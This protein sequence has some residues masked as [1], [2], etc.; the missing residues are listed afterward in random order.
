MML[1][2]NLTYYTTKN[3]ISNMEQKEINL[4]T[5]FANKHAEPTETVLVVEEQ[6]Y[7]DFGRILN[8]VSYKLPK[9]Y[10][11]VVD[12]VFTE[13]EEII[14][15]NEA[16]EAEGLSTL[17][18]PEVTVLDVGND[19]SAKE[20]IVMVF[21]DCI[22][23]N[24]SIAQTYARL[25]KSPNQKDIV[26]LQKTL[27]DTKALNSDYGVGKAKVNIDNLH[28]FIIETLRSDQRNTKE[29][30]LVNNGFS[31][32]NTIATDSKI[33]SYIGSKSYATRGT[34]FEAI[35][36][37][38]VSLFQEIGVD[39]RFEDNWCPGDFYLMDSST[40]P[41]AEN[42]IELNS[43]FA[44]P[45]YPKGDIV[46]ISLK[47]EVAQSGKGTTFISTVLSVPDA[48]NK[49][50]KPTNN[51]SKA[52]KDYLEA[53]RLIAK[54][55]TGKETAN[56]ETLRK[57]LTSPFKLI[58]ALTTDKSKIPMISKFT[59]FENTK[60]EKVKQIKFL[61][62]KHLTMGKEAMTILPSIDKKVLSNKNIKAYS[63]GFEEAYTQFKTFIGRIG[64]KN[65]RSAG[66]KEFVKVIMAGKGAAKEGGPA[67][68]LIKKAECY[69][70][71][72]ELIQKWSD[73]NKAIA[74]PFKRLGAIDNPLLAITM[75]AIAQHGANPDFFKVHGSSTELTGTLELFPAKSKVDSKSMIQSVAIVDSENAAGFNVEYDMKLN[76]VSYTT[77]LAFRFSQSAFRVEVQEL[78]VK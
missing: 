53:K 43:N 18:L 33:K 9:G 70:R 67:K 68:I 55:G 44:G 54:Y 37:R 29:Y 72:I 36:K 30:K 35:R 21:F 63:D 51:A 1:V 38:A 3:V 78:E 76:N 73:K 52:G 11:T 66:A 28:K 74:K 40:I 42:T 22:R 77:K 47:M 7:V 58:Y 56:E 45:S 2:T 57:K 60:A 16:L 26:Q 41:T 71:A 48:D 32:A 23:T 39:L 8:E 17:P 13:R 65:I 24:K 6:K 31:A 15:I 64:I 46:A 14:I 25:Q 75:F 20:A 27:S 69:T 10:P 4:D 61:T 12:G 62:S 19:T 59:Q 49:K 34:T 5:L 50:T